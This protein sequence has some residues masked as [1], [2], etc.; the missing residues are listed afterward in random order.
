M[1]RIQKL[2]CLLLIVGPAIANAAEVT[3]PAYTCPNSQLTYYYDD[4]YGCGYVTWTITNGEIYNE[5]AQ[6]WTTSWS[7]DRS[8]YPQYNSSFPFKIKW[9]SGSLGTIGNADVQVCDCTF[10]W[11]CG[12][13]DLDVTFGP[14]PGT[15]ILSGSSSILNCINEQKVITT[16]S[17]PENWQVVQWNVSSNLQLVSGTGSSATVKGVNTTANGMETLTGEFRFRTDGNTCGSSKYA[18]KDIWLGKPAPKAQTANGASYYS[19]YQICPGNNWVGISWNGLV[20][21]TSWSITPGISYTSNNSELDFTFPSSGYSSV[22]ISVNATNTCGTSYNASYYLSKQ[23]YGCGSFMMATYPNPVSSELSV[24]TSVIGAKDGVEYDVVA[25]EVLLLD[26]TNKSYI[27]LKPS[28]S[29]N[30][31]DVRGLQS[32]LYFLKSKFGKDE[33]TNQIIVEK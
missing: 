25:D 21:S 26:A 32:G 16:A 13:G 23:L 3:G 8:Q 22:S 24:Q 10:T 31:L 17:V 11:I 14:S 29:K 5:I 12:N 19:G 18:S 28:K 6:V 9:G 15:P 7:F 30:T 2:C 33:V 4:S 1:K 27:K 20:S